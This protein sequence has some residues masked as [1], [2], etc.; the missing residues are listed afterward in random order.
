MSRGGGM[1]RVVGQLSMS[2]A[3]SQERKLAPLILQNE[4][5]SAKMDIMMEARAGI[6]PACEDLQS[7][8]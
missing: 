1:G 7:S 4:R 2:A 8:T 3:G 5:L 6:E